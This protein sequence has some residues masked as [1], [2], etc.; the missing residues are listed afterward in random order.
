MGR[1]VL[2]ILPTLLLMGSPCPS[3]SLA[4]TAR[5]LRQQKEKSGVAAKKVFTTDDLSSSPE[6][7]PT[8]DSKPPKKDDA[9]PS[10]TVG[11]AGFTPEMWTRAIKAKKDWIAHLQ[12]DADALKTMRA[13]DTNKLATDPE[14]RKYWEERTIK[15]QMAAQIP[16]EQKK[17]ES[18]QDEARKA[19]MPPEVYEPK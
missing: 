19:G 8:P 9:K 1:I 11:T 4:D 13:V 7:K 12:A 10:Q 3:Q 14:E 17:L 18:M 6:S 15:Q 2:A 16:E 5:Q